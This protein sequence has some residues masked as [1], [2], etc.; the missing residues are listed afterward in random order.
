MKKPIHFYVLKDPIS[1]D[2]KYVGRSVQPKKRYQQHIYSGRKHGHKNQ[3]AAWICSLLDKELKPIME[4]IETLYEYENKEIIKD[5]EMELI[6]EYRKTCD[7][8]NSRDLVD[9]GYEFSEKTRERMSKAQMGNTNKKGTKVSPDGCKK[10][11]ESKKGNTFMRGSKS[12]EETK[13]KLRKAWEIRKPDS[14]EVKKRKSEAIKKWW[15]E[16]KI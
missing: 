16:R 1:L 2:V 6:A 11:G 3:K 8:K 4:I 9:N 5:R 10:I 7:L 14:E 12:T 13:E 15:A